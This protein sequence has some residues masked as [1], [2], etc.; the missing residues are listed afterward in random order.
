MSILDCFFFTG[1]EDADASEHIDMLDNVEES[2]DGDG[3]TSKSSSSS[4]S[5][6]S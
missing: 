1:I 4:V 5:V 3:I 6:C 2:G